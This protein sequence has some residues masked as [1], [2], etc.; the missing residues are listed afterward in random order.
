MLFM[1]LVSYTFVYYSS[2]WLFLV[3]L[4]SDINNIYVS[5]LNPGNYFSQEEEHLLQSV[6]FYLAKHGFTWNVI[7]FTKAQFESIKMIAHFKEA[8]NFRNDH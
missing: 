6:R 1:S 3:C 4:N 7:V 5:G 8:G 2:Y